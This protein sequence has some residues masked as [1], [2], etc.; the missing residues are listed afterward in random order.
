MMKRRFKPAL[1][2]AGIDS[3][4]F[5]DLRHTY[6]STLIIQQVPL[7]YISKQL[8]HSTNKVTLD[9]YVHLMP[10]SAQLGDSLLEN[11][12]EEKD[13]ELEES[14]VRRYGT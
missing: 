6:A 10:E 5:H 1:A 8:G 4:R 14:N 11:L 9:T 7:P 2:L 12:Y 13:A 3:I